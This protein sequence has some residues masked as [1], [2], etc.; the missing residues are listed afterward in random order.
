MNHYLLPGTL[1]DH[2]GDATRGFLAIH[3]LVR[4]LKNRG[5]QLEDVEAKVFG[6]AHSLHT[7][8]DIYKV[9]ERNAVMAFELLKQY[10]IAVV[11][12]HTGG[13]C[14]RKIVFN[15]SNGKVRMRL[16][17]ELNAVAK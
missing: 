15:T 17:N 3:L 10:G 8:N 13:A 2:S 12:H 4:S 5:V 1:D 7:T 16:F 11:A 9:G 6:G 14:G